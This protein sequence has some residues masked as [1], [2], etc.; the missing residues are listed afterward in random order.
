MKAFK[1]IGL[2]LVGI[3]AILLI[4]GLF[5]DGNYAVEREVVIN[6]PKQEVYDY[7][8]YLKNQN[9]FSV[10]A[11]ADPNMKKEFTG[12][13]GT[14]GC[15][16]SWDSNVKDVGKG[17]QKIIK[18]VEGKRIDYE[19]HFIEPFE[20]TDYAY[21]STEVVSENQTKVKWG[22]NGKMKYPMNLMMLAMDM[23]KMLAPDLE[24]GLGNLKNILEQ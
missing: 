22:F 4:A 14:V 18:I 20:S 8:K 11:K 6:K 3:I 16:S 19:L 23:E 7:V 10:W 12:E 24:K 15:V 17:E 21:M 5:I 13:D 9:N 1:I 2:V